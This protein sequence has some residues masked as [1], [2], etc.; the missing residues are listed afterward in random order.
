ML[1]KLRKKKTAKKIWVILTILI[2]PAFVFW[3][4][5]SFIRSKQEATYAGKISGRRVSLLEYKDALDAVRSQAIIQFGDNLSEVEKRLNLESLAWDRLVL[6]S[7]AKKRKINVADQEVIELIQG[8]PFFQR[9]GK[10]DSQIY[11]QMLQYV[12]HAQPRVFE[13]QIRQSL[14]LS[15]LYKEVTANLN[16]SE[17]EVKKEYQ[18]IN[19]QINLYYIAS[20]PPDFIKGVSASEEEIKDY[21]SKNSFQFK[22]PLSFNIEYASLATE[23]KNETAIKDKIKNLALR[24][25]KREDFTKAAGALNLQVKET[26]LFSQTDPIP[27]IG[28]SP[29]ILGLLS[30]LKIGEFM[31]PVYM[32]KYYYILRLKDKKE[33]YIPDFQTIKDKVKE[34][35]IKEAS[36]KIAQQKIE[37]CFKELKAAH[38]TNPKSLDFDK[39]AKNYGLKS[40]STDFFRYGSYVEGIG[41]SDNFFAVAQDLKEDETS[42]I[43]EM[44]SGFYIVKLK[45][46]IPVDEKKFLDEKAEFAKK[47]V[48]QKREEYFSR[49]LEDLK[50][51]ALITGA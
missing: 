28:W 9:K 5:G 37:D 48:S 42:G 39:T 45:S 23:D 18:K 4:F 3:G 12:F 38:K 41:A 51:K 16:L 19:E 14:T 31:P 43:I 7:E 20:I 6:L 10:F 8:Y 22:E 46:K 47:L 21:F 34:V 2:L 1:N 50:R 25:S 32:D 44:P 29:Q 35:F 33:P 26:G 40:D 17:E 27:G 13:E 36:R 24:L 11:S 15:K 30:R 49:F